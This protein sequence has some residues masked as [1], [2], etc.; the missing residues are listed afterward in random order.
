[1]A[2]KVPPVRMA[3]L[4]LSRAAEFLLPYGYYTAGLKITAYSHFKDIQKGRS[5]QEIEVTAV[6]GRSGRAYTAQFAHHFSTSGEIARMLKVIV[7][8]TRTFSRRFGDPEIFFTN[9]LPLIVPMAANIDQFKEYM[10]ELMQLA[11]NYYQKNKEEKTGRCPTLTLYLQVL[12]LMVPGAK[13]VVL[14]LIQRKKISS[15]AA[16]KAYFTALAE[17]AELVLTPPAFYRQREEQTPY[18]EKFIAPLLKV[19]HSGAELV[20]WVE[21]FKG[22]IDAFGTK[23]QP[24]SPAAYAKFLIYLILKT[25]HL[26]LYKEAAGRVDAMLGDYHDK[27]GKHVKAYS[28]YLEAV[29]QAYKKADGQAALFES[30]DKAMKW[31]IY[32]FMDKQIKL[33]VEKTAFLEKQGISHEAATERT[34]QTLLNNFHGF[35]SKIIAA[36]IISVETPEQFR[37]KIQAIFPDF[38]PPK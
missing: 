28:F 34:L 36:M 32:I 11:D 22:R 20:A 6:I 33:R 8:S 7:R 23:Y 16:I 35:L 10:Q 25:K 27:Y 19:A 24:E 5:R 9:L 38:R 29:F 4:G 21:E 26:G 2:Y 12:I 1:M 14:G 3:A 13:K 15:E 17:K 18:L 30:W 37:E 31:A